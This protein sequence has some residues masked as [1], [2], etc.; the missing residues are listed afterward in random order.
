LTFRLSAAYNAADK[1]SLRSSIIYAPET[2]DQRA[3]ALKGNGLR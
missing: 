3:S 2:N 1:L